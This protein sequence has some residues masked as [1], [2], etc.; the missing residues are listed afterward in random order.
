MFGFYEPDCQCTSSSQMAVADGISS[1]N[2]LLA[3]L[4]AKGTILGSP[5]ACKQKD[6]TWLKQMTAKP[7]Q[8][9][10][11]VTSVHINKN[12]LD[13]VKADVDYYLRTYQKPIWVSEFACVDDANG[14]QPCS[15]QTQIDQFVKDAVNFFHCNESVVAYGPSNGEGLGNVWPLI[16][17]DGSLSHTGNTYLSTLQGLTTP[18]NQCT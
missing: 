8:R 13:G 6:E 5:S 4:G 16:A 18:A 17:S 10:W 14:F 1:W 15:D 12:S 3:P 7:L 2:S 9:P 11:D